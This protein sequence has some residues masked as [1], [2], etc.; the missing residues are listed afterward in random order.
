[1]AT[2]SIKGYAHVIREDL[3][4]P[5]ILFLGTEFGLFLSLD[6]GEQWAQ[7]TGKLPNVAVRDLCIQ[8][9]E[10]DLLIATH[11]RGVYIIDDISPI[12]KLND[13]VLSAPVTFFETRPSAIRLP[14]FVQDFPGDDEFVG[15]TLDEVAYITYYLK[16]RHTFGDFKIE[17]YNS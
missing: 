4:K 17:V 3:V 15:S 12:R 13:Q 11:G 1:L 6:S 10:S 14:A 9:R 2:D 5:E 8:P 7:F 16:D